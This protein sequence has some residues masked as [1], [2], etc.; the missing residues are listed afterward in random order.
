M[1]RINADTHA[2]ELKNGI[3]FFLANL[4]WTI[5]LTLS[6]SLSTTFFSRIPMRAAYH[7]ITKKRSLNFTMRAIKGRTHTSTETRRGLYGRR[8][9][10]ES[11]LC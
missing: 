4:K 6:L 3:Q 9:Q 7:F 5:T 11:T 10:P 8:L 1:S 2:N